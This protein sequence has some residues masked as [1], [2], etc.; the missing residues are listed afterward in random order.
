[1]LSPFRTLVSPLVSYSKSLLL[2]VWPLAWASTTVSPEGARRS[3]R[4]VSFLSIPAIAS[5]S[6]EAAY[7]SG[8][9]CSGT[10]V[11]VIG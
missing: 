8:M 11:P 5:E 9:L 7:L 1:M 2:T 3:G 4:A 6:W 10:L